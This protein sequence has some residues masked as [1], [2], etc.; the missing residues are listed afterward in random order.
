MEVQITEDALNMYVAPDLHV[1]LLR[2]DNTA[3]HFFLIV[4]CLISLA[5][6]IVHLSSVS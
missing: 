3:T 4:S 1:L 2:D 6:H 5:L